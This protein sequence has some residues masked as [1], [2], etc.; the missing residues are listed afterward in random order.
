MNIK[1]LALTAAIGL[2]VTGI[3][4]SPVWVNEFHYDNIGSDTGEF[5]EIFVS[6]SFTGTTADIT[7]Q[8]YN[9][10]DDELYGSSDTFVVSTDFSKG[11]DVGS[12]GSFYSISLPSNGL[13]NGGPDGMILW[14]TNNNVLLDGFSYEGTMGPLGDGLGVG[15][16]LSDIGVF[17]S[18]STTQAGSSVYLTG[19]G[20]SS[21]DFTWTFDDGGVNTQNSL[22]VGQSI[23]PEPSVAA[24]A[25]I[26]VG[27]IARFLRRRK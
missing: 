27:F 19:S 11:D 8:L 6:S 18:N 13:Q 20:S 2:T 14:D 24:L 7:L 26:G 12:L 4:A 15:E 21:T 22:N 16:N 3:Q 1:T 17:Q 23:I 5:I 9:G 25:L 10:S